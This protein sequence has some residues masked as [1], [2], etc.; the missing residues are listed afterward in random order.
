MKLDANLITSSPVTSFSF[1]K[2][3]SYDGVLTLFF[4]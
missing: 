1:D 2:E 3:S 4:L